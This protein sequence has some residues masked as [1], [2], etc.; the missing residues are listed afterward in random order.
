MSKTLT[1]SDDVHEALKVEARERKM[2]LQGL[3]DEVIRTGLK[4]KRIAT[5]AP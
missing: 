2:T 1:I 5:V 3:A 4:I